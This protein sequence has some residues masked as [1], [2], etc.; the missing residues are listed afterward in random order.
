[1]LY[2]GIVVDKTLLYK[3]HIK[4]AAEKADRI[5]G[6]LVR[7]MPNVGGPKELRCRLLSSVVHSG[8]LY[9]APSW[10]DTL[11]YVPKNAKILNQA[12]RKVLL[13]H[14][15]AYR[16]VSEVATN[17]LS[18]TPLADIIARDREMAFVR[19]RIQPD[20]EVKTSARANA[21]SR[22]EI[23]LRSWKNRIETAETGA[24]T[25]TLVRDIGSWCNR[26]HGQM[27]FHMTQMMSGHRCFSHYLHRIGKENSDACHHCIDGLDD[28]RHTL[29][30]CDAWESERSTLSRSL[31]GPIRTNSC[32]QHD[33]G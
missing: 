27:M 24:W 29:L 3:E 8:L 9:G 10:A 21:P 30:E 20:V 4:K 16:T 25:R 6:Q 17:I 15:R 19:R 14:I 26:E 13:C 11:D 23:M 18:S 5:G 7:I 2:L 33:C 22:N 12:Q 1:M 32:R 28:A 31:G